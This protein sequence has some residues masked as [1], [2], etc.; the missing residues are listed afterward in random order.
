MVAGLL[1]CEVGPT[2]PCLAHSSPADRVL[3]RL[4]GHFACFWASLEA[5]LQHIEP[6][7]RT[8]S[9]D[10]G[11]RGKTKPPWGNPLPPTHP[12]TTTSLPKPRAKRNTT[13]KR[14][15]CRRR[16]CHRLMQHTTWVLRPTSSE[17]EKDSWRA[18]ICS[19]Q[20]Q[21]RDSA[22]GRRQ[23]YYIFGTYAAFLNPH[24]QGFRFP[25]VGID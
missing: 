11:S 7:Q 3:Q 5:R 1:T 16:R 13:L 15:P 21:A 18:R 20:L 24:F 9:G 23:N 25:D 2:L 19:R 14:H 4:E 6:Q 12:S 8:V 17:K 10:S 22:W